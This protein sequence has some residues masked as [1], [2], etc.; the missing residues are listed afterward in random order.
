MVCLA[1][2]TTS[3]LLKAVFQK[4]YFVLLLNTLPYLFRDS[5]QQLSELNVYFER[6]VVKRF[7][8]FSGSDLKK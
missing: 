5:I 1:D 3:N 8:L 2:H 6:A 7:I 4:F